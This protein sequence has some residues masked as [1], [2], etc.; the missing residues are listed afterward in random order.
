MLLCLKPST[1]FCLVFFPHSVFFLHKKAISSVHSLLCS[2]DTDPR[3]KDPQV[4]AHVAKLYLPLVPIVME[5]LNQLYD[6][7]GQHTPTTNFITWQM[8]T[9][10]TCKIFHFNAVIPESAFTVF[11]DSTPARVRHASA[12]DDADPDIGNIISQSVAMAIA[13]SPLPHAK[14]NPFVLPTVVSDNS[15]GQAVPLGT[16]DRQVIDLTLH[17]SL[18]SV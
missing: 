16:T 10:I 3:Y 15:Q 6:F 17:G 2:H 1:F 13:G 14:A 8:C 5:I 18:T 7:S 9:F 11:V 4:R 12:H